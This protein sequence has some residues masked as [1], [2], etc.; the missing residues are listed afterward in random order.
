MAN[1]R[2]DRPAVTR[3]PSRRRTDAGGD[4]R[5]VGAHSNRGYLLF[6]H[7]IASFSWY[8]GLAAGA[9]RTRLIGP[10]TGGNCLK[11]DPK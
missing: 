2:V 11:G 1:F 8:F 3:H 6:I 10:A 5:A 7:R 9:R 4:S